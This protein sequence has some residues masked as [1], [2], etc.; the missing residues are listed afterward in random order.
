V[1]LFIPAER[2]AA[3]RIL[4][5][6]AL[7]RP[8]IYI[9]GGIDDDGRIRSAA[10]T[11]RNPH[12][13]VVQDAPTPDARTAFRDL[14]DP[15]PQDRLVVG[16]PNRVYVRVHNRG[17]TAVRAEVELYAVKI[18]ADL[19]PDFS[20][21]TLLTPAAAP[22]LEIDVPANDWELAE[23]SWT[24]PMPAQD[25][26]F[27]LIA[28]AKSTDDADP[29]PVRT[30]IVTEELF[31]RFLSREDGSDNVAARALKWRVP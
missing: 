12:I 15:R 2:R 16:A 3:L 10:A 31:W 17:N 30:G 21:F 13:I 27:I 24:P 25:E 11:I 22:R 29:L 7:P 8:D 9:R 28:L 5:V 1:S 19:R 6:A 26:S 20:N 18:N 23:V 14:L 4:P